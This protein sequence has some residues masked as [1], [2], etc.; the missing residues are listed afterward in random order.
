MGSAAGVDAAM[1]AVAATAVPLAGVLHGAGVL[2]DGMLARQ[3]R[4]RF[5]AVMAPKADGAWR[6]HL[7]LRERGLKPDF[8]A[9]YSS[10]SAVLGSLGQGNYVAANAFLDALARWR[11]V[12]D[13]A[14][15][16]LAWGAWKDVGMA[17]RGNTADRAA[18]MGLTPIAPALGH[19]ALGLVL[20]EGFDHVAVT[21]VDWPQFLRQLGAGAAPPLWQDLVA[22]A[23]A[24]AG[25]SSAAG[26]RAKAIDFTALP[27]AERLQQLTAL[28]RTE[29]ATVLALPDGGRSIVDDQP[30][31]SFGLDSLTS[32]ELRNR[33]QAA[34]GRAVPATAAFEWPTVAELASHLAGY[35][36]D[37]AQGQGDP[38]REELTL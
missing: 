22:E 5:A 2:D 26:A 11:V 36:A 8:F 35:F 19:H 33:L 12:N 38:A 6:L 3:T 32:V 28:V 13:E 37:S 20:H 9:M 10:M 14:G 17:A 27:A 7:A 24:A 18:A 15:C 29:L 30:F 25:G 21:P 4:E 34:V 16:S 31:S 1:T 23:R